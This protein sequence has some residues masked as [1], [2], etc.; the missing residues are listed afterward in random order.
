M[1]KKNNLSSE[2]TDNSIMGLINSIDS[3]AEILSDCKTASIPD[4]IDT[5]SYILNACMTGSI[6]GGAPAGRC[7]TL[8]GNPGCLHKNETV[9]GYIFKGTKNSEKNIIHNRYDYTKK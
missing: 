2:S 6:F 5:G 4:Y 3:G 8:A 1:A 7:I 9:F